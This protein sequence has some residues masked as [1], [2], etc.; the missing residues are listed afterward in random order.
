[1][2]S[3]GSRP[4]IKSTFNLAGGGRD[5]AEG[6]ARE[7]PSVESSGHTIAGLK[8]ERGPCMYPGMQVDLEL[9]KAAADSQQGRGVSG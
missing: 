9:R 4:R 7:I 3:L 8:M 5:M 1:M 6:E 2:C